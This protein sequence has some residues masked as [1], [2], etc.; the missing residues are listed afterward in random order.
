[1]RRLEL[2]MAV[3]RFGSESTWSLVGVESTSVLVD[4]I[5]ARNCLQVVVRRLAGLEHAQA[6]LELG[7]GLGHGL[8]LGVAAAVAGRVELGPVGRVAC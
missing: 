8:E 7:P 3:V 5:E 6:A 1:M 4:G 2:D